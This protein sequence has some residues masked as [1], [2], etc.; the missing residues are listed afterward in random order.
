MTEADR[1]AMENDRLFTRCVSL[2]ILVEGLDEEARAAGFSKAVIQA[3]VESRLW[4]AGVYVQM[5]SPA[6]KANPS[7]PAGL[8]I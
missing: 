4:A 3:A 5:N 1:L 2:P 6:E 8:S 7:V